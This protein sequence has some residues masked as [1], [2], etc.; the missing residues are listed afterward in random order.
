MELTHVRYL[1]TYFG[2]L[3]EIPSEM[4]TKLR[5]TRET[6]GV[7]LALL[8]NAVSRPNLTDGER[9]SRRVRLAPSVLVRYLY[10]FFGQAQA[11]QN[12]RNLYAD[13]GHGLRGVHVGDLSQ[14][15]KS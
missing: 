2:Q 9:E 13:S 15:G 12:V 10:T 7:G 5:L 3:Q 4:S 11:A 6:R 1:Y 8:Q 14:C